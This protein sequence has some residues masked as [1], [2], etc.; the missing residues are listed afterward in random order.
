MSR[1]GIL[2][3]PVELLLSACELK[4]GDVTHG[5]FRVV[6]PLPSQTRHHNVPVATLQS[7]VDIGIISQ[8]TQCSRTLS[9][10]ST[11]PG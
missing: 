10:S 6:Y 11:Q 9:D 3:E 8:V 2:G 1:Q 7:L 4:F 5:F